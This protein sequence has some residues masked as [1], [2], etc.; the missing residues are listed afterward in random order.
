M[1]VDPPPIVPTGPVPG[2]S[3][4]GKV[5]GNGLPVSGATVQLYEAGST[6]NG[7]ASAALL[8]ESLTTDG[9]GAFVVPAS[10]SCA[11]SSTVLFLVSKGGR[12]GASSGNNSALWLM[13]PLG[14]CGALS[15]TTTVTLNELTTVASAFALGSFLSTGGN[16]GASSTNVLGLTNAV[17]TAQTLVDMSTGMSPGSAVSSNVSVASDKL[18]ALA[19]ALVPCAALGSCASLFAAATPSTGAAPTNTLDAAW[20][21]ARH[22]GANVQSIY[23]LSTAVSFQNCWPPPLPI[24]RSRSR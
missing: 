5:M 23:A 14:S 2:V 18:Y 1:P 8:S 16:V 13:A 17:I 20:S 12:A 19:D 10:F 4:S 9:N 21:I 6:G 7:S 22:P 24:G 15:S 3:F 11:A